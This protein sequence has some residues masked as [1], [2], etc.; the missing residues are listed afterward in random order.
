MHRQ[1]ISI[2]SDTLF[3]QHANSTPLPRLN[4]QQVSV[5]AGD[6][7]IQQG[8]ACQYFLYIVSGLV[9]V[10][11]ISPSGHEMVLYHLHPHQACELATACL[12]AGHNYP[13]VAIAETDSTALLIPK[14]EFMRLFHISEEF[15]RYIYGD[16]DNTTSNL[17]KLLESLAFAPMEQRIAQFL[18]QQAQQQNPIR[19]THQ[20]IANELG[21]AR[22]VVS[23]QLK[24]FEEN[25]WIQRSRGL[26]WVEDFT[27]LK[28]LSAG[29]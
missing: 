26:I 14:T 8:E 6:T 23:R 4:A 9:K 25:H 3:P 28:Q 22:E 15:Q 29:N 19:T 10:E 20:T 13:A 1:R 5:S 16:L 24:H 21:S 17:L 11:K 2:S 18:Y 7:L 12:L 27:A